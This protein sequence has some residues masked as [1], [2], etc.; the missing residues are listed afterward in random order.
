GAV[1]ELDHVAPDVTEGRHE[2]PDVDTVDLAHS[3]Q[4]ALVTGGCRSVS[5]LN[6]LCL[7]SNTESTAAE[8][9]VVR[10]PLVGSGRRDEVGVQPVGDGL[11]GPP[12]ATGVGGRTGA[13]PVG[14]RVHA[15]ASAVAVLL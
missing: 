10:R 3:L 1:G 8:A 13:L 2:L 7:S 6:L 9:Q 11:V 15:A 5:H 12:R 14:Q 4:T